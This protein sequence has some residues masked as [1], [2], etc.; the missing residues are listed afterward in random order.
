MIKIEVLAYWQID[1]PG[2][3]IS[4]MHRVYIDWLSQNI[5]VRSIDWDTGGNDWEGDTLW[6]R[7]HP[8]HDPGKIEATLK[9]V[10]II[11]MMKHGPNWRPGYLT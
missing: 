1:G 5:G 9:E 11:H 6:F 7:I 10:A 4:A 3:R 8:K 2:S